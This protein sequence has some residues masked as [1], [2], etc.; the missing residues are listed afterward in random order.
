V[1]R[2]AVTTNGPRGDLLPGDVIYQVNHQPV[3]TLAELRAVLDKQGGSE[4]VALQ[5][6]RGGKLRYVEIH[7][8]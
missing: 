4:T 8:E 7:L 5:V 6:E 1:A 2:L 3:S